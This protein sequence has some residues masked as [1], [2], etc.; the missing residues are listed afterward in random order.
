MLRQHGGL[1][2][3]RL[4]YPGEQDGSTHEQ[5]NE[6]E[7]AKTRIAGEESHPSHEYRTDDG[8]EFPPHVG[9]NPTFLSPGAIRGQETI[10][11]EK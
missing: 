10:S 11:H 3:P 6:R 4:P 7:D 1:L 5:N 2:R 9:V 8:G